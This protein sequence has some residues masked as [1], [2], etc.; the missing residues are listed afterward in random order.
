[1]IIPFTAAYAAAVL[2]CL[3]DD[4]NGELPHL[5]ADIG[6]GVAYRQDYMVPLHYYY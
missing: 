3:S 6:G 2:F 1:M 5:P 4:R